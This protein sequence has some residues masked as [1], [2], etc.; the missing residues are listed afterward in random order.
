MDYGI[1]KA[2]F[3]RCARK[4]II[5]AGIAMTSSRNDAKGVTKVIG[6]MA[7]ASYQWEIPRPAGENAGRR[8]D[9]GFA[10]LYLNCQRVD[11][12]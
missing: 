10:N 9:A 2:R 4:Q 11:L 3:S 12:L 7:K 8:D 5:G 1:G 6:V